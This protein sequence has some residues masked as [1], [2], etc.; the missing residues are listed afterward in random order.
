MNWNSVFPG[1]SLESSTATTFALDSIPTNTT[2]IAATGPIV[3]G[4]ANLQAKRM[5]AFIKL[6]PNGTTNCG[7]G[8]G[9]GTGNIVSGCNVEVEIDGLNVNFVSKNT[10][11]NTIIVV[12]TTGWQFA[13]SL[14]NDYSSS[15]TCN[16]SSSITVPST[17]NYFVNVQIQGSSP[18]E[19]PITV[20]GSNGG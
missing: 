7:G 15:T 17:G 13:Q 6:I 12:R 19:F 16:S 10:T 3:P 4:S 18:C 9:T 20:S 2:Y 14:C 5:P 1:Y 8:T 11:A